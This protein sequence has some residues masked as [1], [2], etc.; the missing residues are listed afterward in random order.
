MQETDH[1][2]SIHYT[3]FI[4]INAFYDLLDELPK[5]FPKLAAA[6]LSPSPFL[7]K[8]FLAAR[9]K[10]YDRLMAFLSSALREAMPQLGWEKFHAVGI[11]DGR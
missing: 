9:Q 4:I 7:G 1:K 10:D 2:S 3:Q 8:F 6:M 5:N 11:S